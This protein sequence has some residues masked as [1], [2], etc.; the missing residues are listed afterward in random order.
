MA[1]CKV[2]I[3]DEVNCKL[4]GLDLDTRKELVKKF[5]YFDQ[6]AKYMPAYKLGRWDGCT[7]FFG[8]GG[9]TF[10][11][12]LDRILPLLEQWGYYIEIEDL[13]NPISLDFNKVAET[14]GVI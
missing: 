4:T 9:T 6:K 1:T 7:A 3:I 13:R 2:T 12:M 11:S 14:F 10:V 8:L 5:K